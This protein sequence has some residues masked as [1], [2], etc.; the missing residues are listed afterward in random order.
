MII[1]QFFTFVKREA[2]DMRHFV[3]EEII[4]YFFE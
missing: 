2:I 4:L 1:V 3:T